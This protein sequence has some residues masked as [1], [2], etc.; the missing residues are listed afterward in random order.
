MTPKEKAIE[1]ILKYSK[2]KDEYGWNLCECDSC[3]KKCAL[4]AVDEI[5]NCDYFFN[6]L[7]DTKKFTSY[8][9]EVQQQIEKL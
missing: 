7:K 6:T 3:A 1:L 9:Y 8:W 5:I 2:G 4:I